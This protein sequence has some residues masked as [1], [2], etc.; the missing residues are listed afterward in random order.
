M[1]HQDKL[2]LKYHRCFELRFFIA[3]DPALGSFNG[4]LRNFI[5]GLCGSCEKIHFPE[6]IIFCE[7]RVQ[8]VDHDFHLSRHLIIKDRC[9]PYDDIRVYY[10][11]LNFNCIIFDYTTPGF[12]TG[13]AAL[14]KSDRF[15]G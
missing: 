15:S 1:H 11:L 9:C 12:L 14:A 5:F 10:F 7:H 4:S 3:V 8:P 2:E 6:F 13:K